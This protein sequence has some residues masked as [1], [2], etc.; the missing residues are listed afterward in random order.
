MPQCLFLIPGVICCA[1][2]ARE[3]SLDYHGIDLLPIVGEPHFY[4]LYLQ[5]LKHATRASSIA[6][7]QDASF[8]EFH[9]LHDK[10]VP[11]GASSHTQPGIGSP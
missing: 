2:S 3:M 8:V 7:I 11:L 6:S 5:Q 9:A 1:E 10:A 4:L